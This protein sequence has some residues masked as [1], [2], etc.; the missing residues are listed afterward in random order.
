MASFLTPDRNK[1]Q[2]VDRTKSQPVM[3]PETGV[4]GYNAPLS[5]DQQTSTD[6][7]G[8]VYRGGT[9]VVR[10]APLPASGSSTVNAAANSSAQV[11]SQGSVA[12]GVSIGLSMP[13]EFTVGGTP[14]GA[15]GTFKVAWEPELA[16]E[17]FCAPSTAYPF[18]AGTSLSGDGST[19]GTASIVPGTAPML[20]LL[21]VS[22]NGATVASGAGWTALWPPAPNAPNVPLYAQVLS[23]TFP[24]GGNASLSPAGF[25]SAGMVLLA[26]NKTLA[27]A[28]VQSANSSGGWTGNEGPYS[29]TSTTA[30][31]TIVVVI[32]FTLTAGVGGISVSVSDGVNAYSHPVSS[33]S[34][35]PSANTGTQVDMFIAQGI[36]GGTIN[37]AVH[38]SPGTGNAASY[39]IFILELS[40]CPSGP[41]IPSFKLL[42]GA[43]IPPINLATGGN[44]GVTGDLPYAQVSGVPAFPVTKTLVTSEWLN[45][46][47]STTGDFTATQP[48]FT[49]ISGTVAAAQLPSATGSTKGAIELNTDLG[50]TAAAPEVIATH[51]SSPLPV[52]QGGTGTATPAL[53]PG[54]NVTITGTW[55]NQTINSSGGGGGGGVTDLNT[56]TGSV[57]LAAGTNVTITP[58]GNTLTFA[59]SG[60]GGG[61]GACT[62]FIYPNLGPF[63][64]SSGNTNLSFNNGSIIGGSANATVLWPVQIDTALSVA[65]LYIPIVTADTTGG[66][67]YDFGLYD[68]SGNLVA[69]LGAT[70]FGSTGYSNNGV[71]FA[72]GTV[73][74][75]VGFYWFAWTGNAVGLHIEGNG[76]QASPV[77]IQ[78]VNNFTTG[79]YWF[80]PASGGTTTGGALNS[81]ITPPTITSANVTDTSVTGN[82]IPLFTLSL[83]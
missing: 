24:V 49:D 78:W 32:N 42:T 27:T 52:A 50:G 54:T 76:G 56:L 55:P 45:S 80:P 57:V 72:Q 35:N 82:G 22:T 58:S 12:T 1:L 9:P 65:K 20:A 39:E 41:G 75:P 71:A 61:G 21:A 16:L 77:T 8:Q 51:L 13:G 4:T 68:A 47:D 34:P 3:V 40:G 70:A 33:S 44:G 19:A 48:A 53:V 6:T 66:H 73:S 36:Q 83:F 31:N 26:F 37:L 59:A 25:W 11:I 60:G 18:Q 14:A 46:Y 38:G 64:T 63:I 62:S 23:S 5:T 74:I 2:P 7:I 67:L 30:G 43:Y 81:S 79:P 29:L 17:V 10:L 69:N 15:T 28:P